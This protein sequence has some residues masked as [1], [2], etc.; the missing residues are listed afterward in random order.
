MFW[1]IIFLQDL[2]PTRQRLVLA[3]QEART[4]EVRKHHIGGNVSLNES[5]PDRDRSVIRARLMAAK[6]VNSLRVMV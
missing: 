6:Y 3:N 1:F 4:A 5:T 2:S